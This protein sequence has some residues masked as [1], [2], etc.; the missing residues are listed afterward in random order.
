MAVEPAT[1]ATDSGNIQVHARDYSKFTWMLKWSA[2]GSF[3]IAMI[4]VVLI[5]N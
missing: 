1:N 5:S 2:V 3:I 4:V